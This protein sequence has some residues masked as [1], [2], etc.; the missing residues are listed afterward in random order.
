MKRR[1]LAQYRL[2][3]AETAHILVPLISLGRPFFSALPRAFAGI[4]TKGTHLVLILP[5]L[6]C[7]PLASERA[8][9]RGNRCGYPGLL[10]GIVPALSGLFRGAPRRPEE[11][12]NFF[13]FFCVFFLDFLRVGGRGRERVAGCRHKSAWRPMP[14][15]LDTTADGSVH[16]LVV[17][18]HMVLGKSNNGNF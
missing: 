2:T 16:T 5:L 14:S 6:T 1:E 18:H 13:F 8:S 11:E 15:R 10:G 9:A 7:R 17:P 12:K 3:V 4:V